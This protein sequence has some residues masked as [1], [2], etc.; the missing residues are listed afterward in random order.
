MAF[1]PPSPDLP[2][3]AN[4]PDSVARSPD[5]GL[6]VLIEQAAHAL[7]VPEDYLR[8]RISEGAVA[9]VVLGEHGHRFIPL[10]EYKRLKRLTDERRAGRQPRPEG[11]SMPSQ[12]GSVS[13]VR[14]S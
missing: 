9:S 14:G 4:I 5:D 7:G 3:D 12:T 6:V 1:V 13:P 2:P 10:A 8:Q 11:G